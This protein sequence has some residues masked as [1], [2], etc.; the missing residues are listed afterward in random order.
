[1][2]CRLDR[3]HLVTRVARGPGKSRQRP[4]AGRG[5][6]LL[7]RVPTARIH[8]GPRPAKSSQWDMVRKHTGTVLPS[9]QASFL[10]RPGLNCC[11]RLIL[12]GLPGLDIDLRV[13][14]LSFNKPCGVDLT[15]S[16]LLPG[17]R[18]Q[19]VQA[20]NGP[21]W[22]CRGL[23]P[24]M[25]AGEQALGGLVPSLFPLLRNSRATN[26]PLRGSPRG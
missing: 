3:A 13:W 15:S 2:T 1:M 20:M 6:D 26:N 23:S 17:S 12:A 18:G 10:E 16:Q 22:A 19:R 25:Q 9:E 24:G 11:T 5:L 7:P 14:K 4:A 8:G 21:P